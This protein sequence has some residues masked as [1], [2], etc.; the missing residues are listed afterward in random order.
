MLLAIRSSLLHGRNSQVVFKGS[1]LTTDRN[2]YP[3]GQ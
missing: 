3:F 2:D 1:L